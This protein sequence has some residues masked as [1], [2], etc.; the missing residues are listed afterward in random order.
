MGVLEMSAILMGVMVLWMY[1]YITA[2]RSAHL[3]Y[4]QFISLQ[5]H[6]SIVRL[7]MLSDTR[8]KTGRR[9]TI[10][11]KTSSVTEKP[12]ISLE[13]PPMP[14]F[15]PSPRTLISVLCINF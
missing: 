4:E 10:E 1:T 14:Q 11:S 15:Y 6:L 12:K 9:N 3:K 7:N 8:S 2:D 13:T 5:L